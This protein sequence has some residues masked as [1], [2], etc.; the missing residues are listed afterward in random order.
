MRSMVLHASPEANGNA[1]PMKSPVASPVVTLGRII[2]QFE[3]DHCT[4]AML[5]D[6]LQN[7]FTFNGESYSLGREVDWLSN[8]SRDIEWLILL[9]KFYFAPGLA[10]QFVRTGD[11]RFLDCFRQ[12]VS[13]WLDQ[14]PPGF[15]ATDVTAR[16][17]QNW[18]Y[19]CD[20]FSR[21]DRGCL[22]GEFADSLRMS[23]ATQL[24]YICDNMAPARNHRTLELYA[25]FL[26]SIAFAGL[27][28][29]RKWRQTAVAEMCANIRSDLLDDGVHCEL[30]TDYHHIVLRSY[31]LFVRLAMLNGIDIPDDIPTRVCKA[32]DFSMHV[33]R[34]DG[35]IPALSDSD[36]RSFTTL[37]SW[38]A[39]LFGREDYAYVAS[40]GKS[41]QPPASSQRRFAD[42]GYIVLRS[43]WTTGPYVDARYLVFDCGPVGA[44][45]HGHLDALSIEAAAFG[46]PLVVDPG[47]FT[48]DE[49]GEINWRARFRRT[50]AHNTVTVDDREQ[51]IYAKRGRK[52]KIRNPHPTCVLE[53][54][55]PGKEL[56]YLHGWVSSPNYDAIHHR[57]LWFVGGRYW[58]VVDRLRSPVEHDYV[59]RY[60]LTPAAS[61]QSAILRTEF[62]TVFH[63]PG[64][65]T[66]IVQ[67]VPDADFENGFVS[68][69]YGVRHGAPRICAR[70]AASDCA[71]VTLLCPTDGARPE[72]RCEKNGANRSL[73]IN[74][75]GRIDSWF[76]SRHCETVS[77]E[78]AD[79]SCHWQLSEV[80]RHGQ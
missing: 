30:S 74:I 43:P 58:L 80:S 66:I 7:R 46:R 71:Y 39:D 29:D 69:H 40:A 10:R 73:E 22:N 67:E 65:T 3:E 47:R 70:Q 76:W 6:V 14:T 9:H 31:L 51:A 32:L 61:T 50:S 21:H 33:H 27:D 34:P 18:I 8:P 45:N 59:L 2:P 57:H 11:T 79:S 24:N 49:S 1:K 19:A 28:E 72:W 63:T 5:S 44:G 42:S 41:G 38:G 26:G 12:L 13:S 77:L 55:E 23:L 56:G 16:R 37:L 20:L 17:V 53:R 4:A 68:T 35:L 25:V 54:F 64:L 15:I 52:H 36:S 78:G 62:G 60:Q 75:D 48:Y